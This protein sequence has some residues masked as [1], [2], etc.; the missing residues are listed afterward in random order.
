MHLDLRVQEVEDFQPLRQARHPSNH[1][2]RVSAMASDN[3][4][5]RASRVPIRGQE[6]RGEFVRHCDCVLQELTAESPVAL[7]DSIPRAWLRQF[8][9][10][11]SRNQP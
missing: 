7:L 11:N 4:L 9:N 5:Q 6:R 3:P 1:Q 2:P 8:M 10:I